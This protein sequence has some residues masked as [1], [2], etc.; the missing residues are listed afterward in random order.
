MRIRKEEI[1]SFFYEFGS[2]RFTW[3]RCIENVHFV[4]YCIWIII[5]H[6]ESEHLSLTLR[7]NVEWWNFSNLL[8]DFQFYFKLF[9]YSRAKLK[10]LSIET[11]NSQQFWLN[12]ELH[13]FCQKLFF[14]QGFLW[15][16]WHDASCERSIWKK[17]NQNINKNKD[18]KLSWFMAENCTIWLVFLRL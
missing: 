10:F 9:Q 6:F 5:F 16:E 12:F 7:R 8:C 1:A 18:T 17:K 13:I 4:I 11:W 15:S 2:V 14:G 3:S